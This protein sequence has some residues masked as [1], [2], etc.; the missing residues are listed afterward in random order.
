MKFELDYDIDY[1]SASGIF[2]NR[3]I[4]EIKT[5][6]TAFLTVAEELS[7]VDNGVCFWS[8]CQQLRGRFDEWPGQYK[9]VEKGAA[10]NAVIILPEHAPTMLLAASGSLNGSP[11]EIMGGLNKF[12]ARCDE[13]TPP[14]HDVIK[15]AEIKRVLTAAQ[16][17]YRLL[18]ILAPAYPLKI[19]R[20]A[21]SHRTH[22]SGCG[23]PN[24][25]AGNATISGGGVKVSPRK[26]ICVPSILAAWISRPKSKCFCRGG[27]EIFS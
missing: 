17:T 25:G 11:L 15:L 3:S 13:F 22:N 18:D 14:V 4:A 2:E 16:K 24:N 23:I 5:A 8:L 19:L 26:C 20:F 9:T 6:V 7:G 10:W 12:I 1:S 21:N 27:R